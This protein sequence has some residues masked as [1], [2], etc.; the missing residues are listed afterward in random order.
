MADQETPVRDARHTAVAR[1]GRLKR[2]AAFVGI[3]WLV[4]GSFVAF[5]VVAMHGLDL[6]LAWPAVFGRIVLSEAT[7]KSTACTVQPD[8]HPAGPPR[9]VGPD[10]ARYGAWRLGLLMGQE[11]QIRHWY[12]QIRQR[13][14][15]DPGALAESAQ[16]IKQLADLLGVPFPGAFTTRQVAAANV[17]FLA[18]VEGDSLGTAHQMAVRYSPDAC[19]LYKLG[20]L[21]GYSA[22]VRAHT[23]GHR[24][25]FG[26]EINHYARRLGLPEA[27]WRPMVKPT[28]R[29]ATTEAI[30]IH[31]TQLTEGV[32]K[33]LVGQGR[34]S[35][36]GSPGLP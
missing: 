14:A 24:A 3:V 18:F 29:N 32:T 21:W 26:V 13:S 6:A 19:Q 5:E 28:P 33:H 23:A 7:Q 12:A 4:A 25:V 16:S 8:E 11:A 30:A 20:A 31:T 2:A 36:P 17:E 1:P 27:L 22:P 34:P 35:D 15:I 9:E 10:T